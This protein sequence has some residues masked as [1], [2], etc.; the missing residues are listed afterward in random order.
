M[1]LLSSAQFIIKGEQLVK[2]A[3]LSFSRLLFALHL[4]ILPL[5]S[6]LAIALFLDA[7][8]RDPY[9]MPL[10]MPFSYLKPSTHTL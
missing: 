8:I 10:L 4:D 3:I 6:S 7:L 9:L 5:S 1:R 2:V